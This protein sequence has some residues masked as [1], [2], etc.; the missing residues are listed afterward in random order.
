M[1]IC[2]M[3]QKPYPRFIKVRKAGVLAAKAGGPLEETMEERLMVLV[4]NSTQ[5]GPRA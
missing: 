5:E 2:Y 3:K 1:T 4:I